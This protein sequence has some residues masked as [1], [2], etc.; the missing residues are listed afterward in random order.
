MTAEEHKNNAEPSERPSSRGR[1]L[2]ATVLLLLLLPC[3][4]LG[5]SAVFLKARNSGA[6]TRWRSIGSPPD[7]GVKLVSGDPQVIYVR[8][9]SEKLYACRHKERGSAPSCWVPA[10]EPLDV[11]RRVTTEHMRFTGEVPLPPGQVVDTLN[12]ARWYAED[13]FE[14]R[15]TLLAD[16][17]VWKWEYDVGG[18]WS[19]LTMAAGLL[20]GGVLGLVAALVIW[21]SRVRHV[22]RYRRR[23]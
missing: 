17:S 13:A 18:Y 23:G 1:L 19:L 3:L 10:Q 16:G 15:Y 2:L 7:P 21:L 4:G 22:R 11:D 8:T 20:L 9:T 14:T 5:A 12:V 6:F